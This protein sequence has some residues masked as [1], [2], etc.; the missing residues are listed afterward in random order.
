LLDAPPVT[1]PEGAEPLPP[2]TSVELLLTIAVDGTVSDA[3]LEHPVR[4]DV[5][6]LVLEAARV[7]LF[8]PATRDGVPVP[9]RIRF[10]YSVANALVPVVEVPSTEGEPTEG[11]EPTAEADPVV[12]PPRAPP[13]EPAEVELS[14]RAI[15]D[16]PEAGAATRITLTG[17]ELSTVPGT[18]GEPL[19]VVATLPGVV[20]SPFGLGFFLVRGA[21]FQNTGFF[22]D[23]FPVP[24]LYHFGA[25]PAVISSRLVER[26][27]FYPGGYPVS[28]GRFSAG[29]VSIETG[30]PEAESIHVEAEVDL[31]RASLLGVLPFDDGRG[32]ITVALRRSYY[33]LLI[34]LFISGLYIAYTDWQI[35]GSYRFD[36][37]FEL[38]VFVF[39]SEDILDQSGAL[40]GGTTSANSNTSIAFDFQRAIGRLDWDLPNGGHLRLSGAI[41]H[42][43]QVFGS[44]VAGQATQNFSIGNWLMALRLDA[45]FPVEDWLTINAGFDL[46]GQTFTVDVTA[47]VPG[48]LGEYPRPL[49]DPQL[50]NIRST[51]ARGLPGA[52][53]ESVFRFDPVE[54]SAGIRMEILRYGTLTDIAPDPRGVLRWTIIPELTAKIASGLFT[55]APAALQTISVAG[56]PGLAPQR[57]WQN[58]AGL[59]FDL[60]LDIEAELTGFY[61]QM[62][63]IARFSQSTVAGSDGTPRREFFRADQEGRAWG[64]EVL[65][66][67]PVEDGFYG[68][69]SYTLSRS[70]RRSGDGDWVPF[71]FDQT[72]T[73]NL[74]ASY[75]FDGWRFGARFQLSTGRPTSSVCST[76]FDSDETGYAVSFCDRGDRLPTYH[77]LD[78]RID[79]DFNIDNVFTGTIYL[80]VLNVYNAQNA[81]G[82]IYSFDYQSSTPLPGLPILGTLGIR[83]IL[84]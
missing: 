58:S 74:A 80:D 26:L 42:E 54:I 71:A 69:V 64:L 83:M 56:N 18:F 21:N 17:A 45:I 27:R 8:T 38:S 65:V 16:R 37:G 53:A 14:V 55:Q 4:Q 75:S 3:Q 5:D 10:R 31:L 36:D 13:E 19:R 20:R 28:L 52:Y 67:R 50:V 66:R 1:L 24:I 34:P 63:D 82:V 49:F 23:G 44:R 76:T 70:E 11:E 22:V 72:H 39:G 41:G 2:D 59:E 84:E 30:S 15:V 73:L 43:N 81:E 68:W 7:M 35:R 79:R 40:G 47:P 62:F 57:A 60:P 51:V 77:Q 78:V 25:G 12:E 6:P 33:D 48:G 61:S 9:S 32:N 46:Q 29:V